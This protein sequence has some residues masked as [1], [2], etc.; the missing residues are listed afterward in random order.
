M[1]WES[2]TEDPLI[3]AANYGPDSVFTKYSNICMCTEGVKCLHDD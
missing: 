1:W 3:K 2:D